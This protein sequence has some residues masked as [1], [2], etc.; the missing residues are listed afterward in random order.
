MT[1][2]VVFCCATLIFVVTVLMCPICIGQDS[3]RDNGVQLQ[4]TLFS[5][6]LAAADK[7]DDRDSRVEHLRKALAYR[8]DHPDNIVIEYRIGIELSQRSDPEHQQWP[9]LAEALAVFEHIMATY[10]HMDYYSPEPVDRSG[11][12]QLMVPQAAILAACIQR[13]LN[14]NS[15]RSKEYLVKAME[16][17]NETYKKRI[18]DWGNMAAT[19]QIDAFDSGPREAS[20]NK[21]RAEFIEKRKVAAANGEVFGP[22]EMASVKAAVRQFGYSYGRQKPYEVPLVMGQIVKMFPGTPMATVAQEH[23]QRAVAMSDKDLYDKLPDSLVNMPSLS[24]LGG[25][26]DV[27]ATPDS[28]PM[29]T[30]KNISPHVASSDPKRSV[31]GGSSYY[32]PLL[33]GLASC[34][35][36][37]AVLHV[38]K[39]KN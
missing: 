24:Q 10:K 25:P 21:S 6:E 15:Q 36:I 39:K 2:Q 1:K 4:E 34:I 37:V 18:E 30:T 29:L 35:V 19:S 26:P 7:A 3:T 17:L 32:W 13:G 28:M 16:Q 14:H 22:L 31:S 9:R 33:G 27:A 12:A 8:P 20:K 38:R 23:M 5:E 11:V